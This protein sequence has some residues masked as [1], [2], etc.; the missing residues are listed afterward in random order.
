[1]IALI[2]LI[3]SIACALSDGVAPRAKMNQQ[4]SRRFRSAQDA[5]EKAMEEEKI[6]RDLEAQGIKVCWSH[7]GLLVLAH[8]NCDG[9]EDQEGPGGSG[10]K[11]VLVTLGSACPS[12]FQL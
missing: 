10:H 11:G 12:S 4:R 7:L 1:M 2:A 6:R 3:V 5:E 9:G 8:F